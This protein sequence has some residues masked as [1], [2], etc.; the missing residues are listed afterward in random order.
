MVPDQGRIVVNQLASW[1]SVY[2]RF[3]VHLFKDEDGTPDNTRTVANFTECDFPGYAALGGSTGVAWG[4]ASINLDD[5]AE[6]QSGELTWTA[7]DLMSEPQTIK[8]MYILV[9]IDDESEDRMLW[10]E[11]ISPTVT[12]ALPGEQFQRII[13]LQATDDA[14]LD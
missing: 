1:R 14:S 7:S 6:S 12:L 5:K 11:R 10:F 8:G 13:D 4:D 3:T 9:R 2:S